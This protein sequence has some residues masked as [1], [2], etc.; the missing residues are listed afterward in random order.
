MELQQEIKRNESQ[1]KVLLLM[2]F[3]MKFEPVVYT[4][5]TVDFFG[6]RGLSWHGVVAIYSDGT[7]GIKH[8]YIDQIVGNN[9]KQDKISVLSM[10]DAALA[11][12][13]RNIP[14][15]ERVFVLSDNARCYQNHLLPIMIHFFITKGHSLSLEILLHSET[16][17]GKLLVD[18]HF[19]VAMMHVCRYVDKGNSVKTPS[20]LVTAINS[21]GGVANTVADLV[22]IDREHVNLVKWETSKRLCKFPRLNEIQYKEKGMDNNGGLAFT[23]TL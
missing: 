8:L 23:G 2:D 16:Q 6:K 4:E 22:Y 12:V 21:D 5:K 9:S 1:T 18:T 11:R 17:D 3:K 20:Q 13:K 10:Y 7:G 19:A 15:V 14:T